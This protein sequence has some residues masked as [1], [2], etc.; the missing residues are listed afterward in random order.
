MPEG[1]VAVAVAGLLVQDGRNGGGHLVGDYLILV[2]EIDPSELVAAE[3]GG[4][5]FDRRSRVVGGNVVG[6]VGP[7]G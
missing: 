5:S 7:L 2:G 1:S 6:G 4:Q 3:D